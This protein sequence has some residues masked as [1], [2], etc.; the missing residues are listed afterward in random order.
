MSNHDG[1]FFTHRRLGIGFVGALL[2]VFGAF[3]LP[4]HAVAQTVTM[5]DGGS[6]AS[7][8]LGSSAG[9]NSWTVNGQNQLNQQW[10]WYQTDGGVAQPI[11]TISAPT[12]TTYN[13]ANGINE[14]TVV[15]QNSKLSLSIDYFLTGGGMGSGNA[16]ITESI[17]AKN[18]SGGNLNLNFYQYSAF[19]L[20]QAGHDTVQILGNP[21]A[22]TF[23]RQANGSTAIQEAV[24]APDAMFA[25]AADLG[26]TLN[27]LN[28][29]TNLNLNDVTS[30]GPGLETWSLQWNE[31]LASGQE[32]DLTKDKS[33]SIQVTPEPSMIALLGLGGGA[34]GFAFRRKKA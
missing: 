9:M 30:A 6:T 27:R 31:A 20:L 18:I 15:Y 8:D 28:T 14:V 29:V 21:G 32:F 33:L 24:T 13:G 17:M 26:Y 23:V 34:L 7:I 3:F 22:Y 2:A 16:D 25:E 5:N 10:F 1:E 12:Y 11:N 4:G 19:N